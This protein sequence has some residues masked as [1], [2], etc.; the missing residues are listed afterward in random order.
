MF[1]VEHFSA[2]VFGPTCVQSGPR[3]TLQRKEERPVEGNP[4]RPIL[5][6][7]S[8]FFFFRIGFFAAGATFLPTTSRPPISVSESVALN[9]YWRTEVCP[10]VFRETSTRR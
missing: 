10:V 2:L 9:G 6:C 3:S 7:R 1:H 5:R 4:G 8:Y